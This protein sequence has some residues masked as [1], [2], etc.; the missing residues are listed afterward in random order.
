MRF[1]IS[2]RPNLSKFMVYIIFVFVLVIFAIWLGPT[3]FSTANIMNITRQSGATAVM[4]VSMVFVIGMGH[5]DLSIGSVVALSA[6]IISLILQSTGN[7][8]LALLGGL[9]MGAFVGFVNGMAVVKVKIP[10]FLAT[11]GTQSIIRGIAMWT[12]KTKAV[13]IT[14][15]SFNFWFGSGN[16]AGIPVLLIWTIAA[17]VISAFALNYTPYGKRV[18]ATGGNYSAAKYSGVKVERLTV[19]VFAVMGAVS[20]LAGAL[21][22][23]RMNT[24]RWSYGE[25]VEMD[26]IAAVVLGGTSMAGGNG[27]AV[28]A[29]IGAILINMINNGLVIGGFDTAQQTMMKGIIILLAVGLGSIGNKKR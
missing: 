16:V 4:A 29:I 25:G 2:K 18:M 27:S 14:K 22:A 26:V 3:F 7:I 8:A 6:M 1:K 23:G 20:A 15:E 19:I 28:G 13:P 12:T 5:I 11:L 9:G 24:A 10:A 21:F 17:L